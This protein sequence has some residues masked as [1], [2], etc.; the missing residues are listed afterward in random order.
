M[1]CERSDVFASSCAIA[2]AFPIFSRRSSSS[3]RPEK[4]HVTVEFVIIGQENSPLDVSE[5]KVLL[6]SDF[7]ILITS[8]PFRMQH[9]HVIQPLL[10]CSVSRQ[11]CWWGATGSSHCGHTMQ[12]DE[13]RS[14]PRCKFNC[15]SFGIFA[16]ITTRTFLNSYFDATSS[17]RHPFLFS[18]DQ[19]C[20]NWAWNYSSDH[21][22][23]RTETERVWRYST[24]SVTGAYS[25]Y[26]PLNH[27][28]ND[29]CKFHFV[30]KGDWVIQTYFLVR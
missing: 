25:T 4:K 18:G 7:F 30:S 19:G 10:S 13:Y 20:G 1:V 6:F 29:D 28:S 15:S 22:W 23:R 14:L 3:R 21:S 24:M 2:R 8:G 26:W 17:H 5:L 16:A 9:K 12:W 11:C 27:S